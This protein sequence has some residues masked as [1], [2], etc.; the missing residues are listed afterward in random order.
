M[1]HSTTPRSN[2]HLQIAVEPAKIRWREEVL[3]EALAEEQPSPGMGPL[4]M[5]LVAARTSE[6]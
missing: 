6:D 3:E 1:S 2:E 4:L 5:L